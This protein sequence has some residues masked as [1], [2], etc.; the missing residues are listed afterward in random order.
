MDHDAPEVVP[1]RNDAIHV[2]N[3]SQ[4][5]EVVKQ[6]G[7]AVSY[8]RPGYFP[9]PASDN[10]NHFPQEK[11]PH[12]A[13]A[14]T[15]NKSRNDK[16]NNGSGN[17]NLGNNTSVGNDTS[18]TNTSS[19]PTS[20]TRPVTSGTTGLAEFSCADSTAIRSSN[21]TIYIADCYI[22]YAVGRESY[23]D[24]NVT[25]FNLPGSHT[26]Y[27]LEDCLDRCD[28]FQANGQ[29]PCRAVTYYANL[30]FPSYVDRKSDAPEV[31]PPRE[32]HGK[33]YA[34]D[35]SQG[36]EVVKQ[37][38]PEYSPIPV[39]DHEHDVQREKGPR[40]VV[41]QVSNGSSKRKS[42]KWL[43]VALAAVLVV[44]GVGLG[45][46]LGV[47]LQKSHKSSVPTTTST[48]YY[49]YYNQ[50]SRHSIRNLRHHRCRSIYLAGSASV[51]RPNVTIVNLG[52]REIT[53]NIEDCLDKCDK[54][55]DPG[56]PPCLAVTYYANLTVPIEKF[57]RNRFLK[58]D[59]SG[60]SERVVEEVDLLHSMSAY[61]R[62]LHN[63]G[64]KGLL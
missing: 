40:S 29:P 54:F 42:R 43:W 36:P 1:Y 38:G 4:G 44:L 34:P 51:P 61:R 5:P 12:N 10:D 60:Y 59:R 63:N 15:T 46:G 14:T 8:N 49:G 45:A 7:S 33:I 31:V 22:Q 62:C 37:T 3:D 57:G 24:P 2:P 56:E 26:V 20:D 11:S 55:D 27:S 64:C 30:D 23:Y 50:L 53:Y 9:L 35:Y 19:V 48:P 41:D 47:G 17:S 28:Q 32:D 58:N 21:S 13:P 6:T 39:H 52:E 25:V 18:P 16:D